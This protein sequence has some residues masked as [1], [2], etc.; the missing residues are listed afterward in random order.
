MRVLRVVALIASLFALEG[1][2]GVALT[3]GTLAGGAGLDHAIRGVNYKTFA[4]PLPELRLATLKSLNRMAM[5]VTEERR[6]ERREKRGW[7]IGASTTNR[8]IDIEFESITHLATR[9]RVV[10]SKGAFFLRDG[11][12]SAEIIARTAE[13]LDRQTARADLAQARR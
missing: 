10:V 6:E 7:A 1:C 8:D 11:V 9:I 2:V 13:T 5:D 12:T 4:T 3:A